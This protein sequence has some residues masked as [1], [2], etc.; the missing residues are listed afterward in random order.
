MKKRIEIV[1][2]EIILH[3]MEDS[4]SGHGFCAGEVHITI[5]GDDTAWVEPCSRLTMTEEV[6][7]QV[8]DF[9][10]PFGIAWI[11]GWHDGRFVGRVISE[12]GN[13]GVVADPKDPLFFLDK[14]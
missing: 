3:V 13:L 8:A 11:R 1:P 9:L 7:S 12:D 6:V 4:P 10:R 5:D 14:S 2:Y